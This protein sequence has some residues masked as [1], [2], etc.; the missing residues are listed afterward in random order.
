MKTVADQIEDDARISER[1]LGRVFAAHAVGLLTTGMAVGGF[2]LLGVFLGLVAGG[3][4]SLPW[5]IALAI[6]IWLRGTWL[7][8]HPFT[9]A[10]CGPLFVIGSWFTLNGSMLPGYVAVSCS[11]SSIVFLLL[12][13]WSRS[14]RLRRSWADRR[15][16]MLRHR[17]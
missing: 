17:V 9:F 13:L 7:E 16:D 11:I 10:I 4:M 6:A 8:K 14:A 3:I 5:M 12:T 15:E 2:S 1:L